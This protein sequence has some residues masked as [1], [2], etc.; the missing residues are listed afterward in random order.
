MKEEHSGVLVLDVEPLAPVFDVLK[1][2]DVLLAID[3]VSI[4]ND[5]TIAYGNSGLRLRLSVLITSHAVG[6]SI[7]FTVLRYAG[8]QLGLGV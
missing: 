2:H 1:K 6:D 7:K 4:A 3:G 8:R 5:G